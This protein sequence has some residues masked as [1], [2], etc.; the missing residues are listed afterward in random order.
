LGHIIREPPANESKPYQVYR[1]W[2]GIG[3]RAPDDVHIEDLRLGT[4]VQYAEDFYFG[5]PLVIEGWLFPVNRHPEWNVEL[6]RASFAATQT[7]SDSAWRKL[8]GE[9]HA[10]SKGL[11]EADRILLKFR[12]VES[13]EPRDDQ[14]LWMRNDLA[15]VFIV[16]RP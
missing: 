9:R 13:L 2:N 3:G 4:A 1:N 6:L 8:R 7:L 15:E 5:A 14:R 10:A 16:R 12:E 11:D